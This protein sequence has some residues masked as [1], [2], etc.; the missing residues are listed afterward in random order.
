MF[1]NLWQNNKKIPNLNFKLGI[2]YCVF[3]VLIAMKLKLLFSL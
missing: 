3:K 1:F 2:N